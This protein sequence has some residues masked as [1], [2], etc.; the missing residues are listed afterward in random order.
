[1]R[2]TAMPRLLGRVVRPVVRPVGAVLGAVAMYVLLLWLGLISLLWNAVAKLLLIGLALRRGVMRRPDP[3]WVASLGRAGIAHVYRLFWGTAQRFGLMRIDASALDALREHP[4][5]LIIAANHPSMLD[6]LLIV[7]RLPRAVCIM[8]AALSRN[9]FLG[10]GARLARYIENESAHRMVRGA[11][12]ELRRGALLVMFPEGTRTE[13][14]PLDPFRAG[15]TLV[16]HL[17]RTP[18]QTVFI[19]TDSPYLRKGWPIWR[20]P[21]LPL[22]FRLRLGRRF[23]PQADHAKLLRTLE[24]YFREGLP[25]R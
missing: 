10:A 8:K 20:V 16:A 4:G 25:P 5:G 6:A 22:Q 19:E 23:E 18:I 1:M 13:Q 15:V 9:I 3:P 21:A 11:V 7:A 12:S 2:Q 24:D 17:A 14:A